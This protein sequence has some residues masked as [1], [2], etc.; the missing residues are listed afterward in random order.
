MATK[1]QE[2]QVRESEL[3]RALGEQTAPR[4][5]SWLMLVGLILAGSGALVL[6]VSSLG[7]LRRKPVPELEQRADPELMTA[8]VSA[9]E[10]ADWDGAERLFRTIHGRFPDNTRSQDYLDRIEL[11]RRDAETLARAE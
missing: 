2:P 7:P 8:A 1:R 3:L 4:P 6:L 10:R 9:Y 5:V 11:T